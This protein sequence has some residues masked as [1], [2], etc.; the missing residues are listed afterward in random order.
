MLHDL[1]ILMVYGTAI[2][3]CYLTVRKNRKAR[4]MAQSEPVQKRKRKNDEID[5][6]YVYA[7]MPIGP[8]RQG[9]PFIVRLVDNSPASVVGRELNR[10]YL[11]GDQPD[12]MNGETEEEYH[13]RLTYQVEAEAVARAYDEQ[14]KAIFKHRPNNE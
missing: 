7:T 1:I 10:W 2:F 4:E 8:G 12:M 14:V 5:P 6:G 3:F 11:I 9:E 13:Q